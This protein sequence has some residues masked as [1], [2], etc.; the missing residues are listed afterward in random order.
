MTAIK[1]DQN[2]YPVQPAVRQMVTSIIQM[3]HKAMGIG[4]QLLFTLCLNTFYWRVIAK[5][6]RND[7]IELLQVSGTVLQ[8]S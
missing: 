4:W 5:H 2:K 6:V 7:R 3:P 8:L 1:N